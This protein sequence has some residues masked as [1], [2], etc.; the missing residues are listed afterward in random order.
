[1][2]RKSG[3]PPI[4]NA[5]PAVTGLAVLLLIAQGVRA[6]APAGLG[7]DFLMAASLQPDRFWATFGLG[8]DGAVPYGSVFGA[9]MTLVSEA[10]LHDGWGGAILNAAFVVMLGR[11]VYHGLGGTGQAAPARFLILFICSVAGGSL[12]HLV[13]H[14]PSGVA[15]MGASGGASGLLSAWLLKA[16]GRNGRIFSR[17][18]LVAFAAF[19]AVNVAMI[20]AGPML[21]GARIGWEAHIGG[22]LAGAIAFR[23][24]RPDWSGP[25]F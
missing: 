11:P 14:F 21:L 6:L 24:L 4:I 17:K 18:F 25:R 16:D 22:F 5:P 15:L 20:W 23:W 7:T 13:T 3:V 1:M 10:L 2:A 8:A 12:A 9:L 19:A